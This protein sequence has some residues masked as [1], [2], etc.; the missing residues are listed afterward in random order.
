MISREQ[1][2]SPNDR[3]QLKRHQAKK[4]HDVVALLD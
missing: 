1:A 3:Q 4:N 2:N